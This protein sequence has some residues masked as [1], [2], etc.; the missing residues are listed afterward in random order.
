MHDLGSLTRTDA[1]D[2]HK[3]EASDSAKQFQA[4]SSEE[5]E[6]LLTFLDSL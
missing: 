6:Q 3:G 5:K 1:I 2:R 4:L